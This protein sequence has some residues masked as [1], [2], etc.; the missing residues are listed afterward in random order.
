MLKAP[1][2]KNTGLSLWWAWQRRPPPLPSFSHSWI[3][4]QAYVSKLFQQTL[5]VSVNV[6][7][8]LISPWFSQPSRLG[9]CTQ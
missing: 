4:E 7:W 3:A 6:V 9:W 1:S 8:V 5:I 2:K